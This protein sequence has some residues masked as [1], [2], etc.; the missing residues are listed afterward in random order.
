MNRDR[1]DLPLT[2]ASDRAAALY[3]DGVDRILAAWHGADAALDAAIAEDPDFALAHVARARVHQINME[4]AAARAEAAT[5]RQL[6]A[7]ASRRELQ[8]VDIVASVVEGQGRQALQA[9]EQHLAEF[10]R[11]AL[12]LAQLLGAFGLYAFSGRPDHDAARLSICER[13]ASDYGNDWWFL[14][15]LGWSRTEAG[16]V[17]TGR[18]I[19]ERAYWMKP[20]NASA[21]HALSHAL[22]EQGDAAES[23]TF[24]SGWLPAHD[25][26]SFLQGHLAWHLA[27]TALEDGDAD[28]AFEIYERHI[29]P[30]GRPYPPINVLTDTAS[31]LWRLSLAGRTGLESH[32]HEVAAY[33]DKFFPKAGAHFADVHHALAAAT[34]NNGTLQ[35]RLAEMEARLAEGKLAPGASTIGLCRGIQAFASGDHDG[36]V[37]ILEPLMPELVRIGGSH[38]QRELWEDTFIVACLRAGHG[39]KA[40]KLIA[41]RLHRRPS[42]RDEAW[43]RETRRIGAEGRQK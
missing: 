8:H 26:V 3:R 6:A 7:T 13:Y 4:G 25:R 2:T 29:R 28:G 21:A 42:R 16:D 19:T 14:T 35:P 36:A 17:V 5:A 23:R 10:P 32:W 15:Y 27:L 43:S 34:T 30:Q 38:A 18:D 41:E 20:A 31:L 37:R 39:E 24:L 40:T 9:A 1:Y 33:S 22:F 12:I 11:D